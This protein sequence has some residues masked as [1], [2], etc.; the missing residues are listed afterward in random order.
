[1]PSLIRRQRSYRKHRDPRAVKGYPTKVAITVRRKKRGTVKWDLL[2]Q[3]RPRIRG[4]PWKLRTKLDSQA[5]QEERASQVV[6]GSLQER[7]LYQALEDHDLI[8]GVDFTFQTAMLGGRAEFG[9][10]VADFVFEIPKIVV[11]VQSIWHT[12]SAENRVRDSD[13]SLL[14]QSWGY[15]ILEIWPEDI[16]D[17]SRL[18]LWIE[19][20][21][22]SL[23]GTS[24]GGDGVIGSPAADNFVSY[25]IE[26][27]L[28]NIN[29]KLNAALQV[30][31]I[32]Q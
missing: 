23:W 26:L 24:K 6:R 14:L 1:M 25:L 16:M 5:Y 18:D 32:A 10:L 9:G 11:Q 29:R 2:R 27:T 4:R 19:R 30:A 22:M 17:E 20:N 7:I 13:Q 28:L 12:I 21:I 8:A 31:G 15:T 3:P